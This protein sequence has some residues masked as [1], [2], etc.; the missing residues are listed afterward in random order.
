MTRLNISLEHIHRHVYDH[1]TYLSLIS[2]SGNTIL[3]IGAIGKKNVNNCKLPLMGK[4]YLL[5]GFELIDEYIVLVVSELRLCHL[6]FSV[7][8]NTMKDFRIK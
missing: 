8:S 5:D 6:K 7:I 2:T 1:L 4:G 3:P